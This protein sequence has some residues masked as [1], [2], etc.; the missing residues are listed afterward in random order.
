MARKKKPVN[1]TPAQASVR[2]I[3]E[4]V[5]NTAGRSEKTSWFRKLDN[6]QKLMDKLKPLEEQIIELNAQKMPIVDQITELRDVMVNE[7]VHPTDYL[8]FKGSYIDCKFCNRKLSLP[9][10]KNDE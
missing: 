2:Q 7:C 3:L 4:T 9:R 5:A 6:M 1:E 10:I 8:I